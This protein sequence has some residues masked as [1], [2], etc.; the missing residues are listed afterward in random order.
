MPDMAALKGDAGLEGEAG[1]NGDC[2]GGGICWCWR[3]GES[4]RAGT[5][6]GSSLSLM[7]DLGRVLEL[8]ER[9]ESTPDG[10]SLFLRGFF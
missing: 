10:F 9:G 3:R 7:G 5:S 2:W 4:S 8:C 6:G 1:R